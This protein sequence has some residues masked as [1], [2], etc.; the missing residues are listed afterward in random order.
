MP[1]TPLSRIGVRFERVP[2]AVQGLIDRFIYPLMQRKARARQGTS[3]TGG[4]RRLSPR[5]E[6]EPSEGVRLTLLPPRP[7]GALAR[8]RAAD[9]PAADQGLVCVVRD[10]STTGCA[11]VC[12]AGRLAAGQVVAIKLEGRGLSVEL[13]VKVVNVVELTPATD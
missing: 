13:Q 6:L 5:V 8:A 10:L 3:P 7:L 2:P 1:E 4:E 11:F 12:P 9:A